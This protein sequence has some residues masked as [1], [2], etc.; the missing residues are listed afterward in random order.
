[1]LWF[2]KKS[3]FYTVFLIIK[4]HP[5][6][7]ANLDACNNLHSFCYGHYNHVHLI[8]IHEIDVLDLQ[9]N[10]FFPPFSLLLKFIH[11]MRQTWILI[12][13]SIFLL[14]ALQT[15]SPHWDTQYWCFGFARKASLPTIFLIIK[16]YLWNETNMDTHNNHHSFC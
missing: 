1:M 8:R 15:C 7:E 5:W 13:I 2:G 3:F 10:L 12:I 6:N 4:V 16:V 14:W 9:E 11:G